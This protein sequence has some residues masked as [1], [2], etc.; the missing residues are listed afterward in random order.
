MK[1]V[2]TSSPYIP[3][4]WI[5]AHGCEPVRIRPCARTVHDSVARVEGLCPYT[6]AWVSDVLLHDQADAIVM[7]LGAGLLKIA[8]ELGMTLPG[9]FVAPVT[10]VQIEALVEMLG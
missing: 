7:E 1:Q 5:R 9:G 8:D 10:Q 4:A 6:Q 2:L 3:P